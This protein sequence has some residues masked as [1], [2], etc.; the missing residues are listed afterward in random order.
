MDGLDVRSPETL[1]YYN[2]SMTKSHIVLIGVALFGAVF[3]ATATATTIDLPQYGFTIKA[4][5]APPST[6]AAT[7]ALMTF[8]PVSDGFAPNVNVNIQPYS[9]SMTSY[10]AMSKDQFKQMNWTIVVEKQNGENE[11][12][13][14]YTGPLQGNDLHFYARAVGYNGKVY[15]VTATAKKTQ[16][17]S[18]SGPLR[19][20]VDSF[21]TK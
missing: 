8:L 17:G 12:I 15:L 16:W 2:Q 3:N 9:G 13:V 14:E 5:D 21:K 7:T 1:S 11:W 20:A 18:V 10:V 4:L 6:Q 19:N